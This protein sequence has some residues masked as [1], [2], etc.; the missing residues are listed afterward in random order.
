MKKII[1]F[2]LIVLAIIGYQY[3]KKNK[4]EIKAKTICTD[5]FKTDDKRCLEKYWNYIFYIS[6]DLSD[7]RFEEYKLKVQSVENKIDQLIKENENT[8]INALE[9][10]II[11][12][13]EIRSVIGDEI[14][15]KKV[16][17]TGGN[18]ARFDWPYCRGYFSKYYVCMKQKGYDYDSD[19]E[20]DDKLEVGIINIE[21]FPKV[22][23]I[24]DELRSFNLN[25]YKI[26]VYGEMMQ[27][28]FEPKIDADFI[29][30][31]KVLLDDDTYMDALNS[32]IYDTL[33]DKFTKYYK[34]KFPDEKKVPRHDLTVY[35]KP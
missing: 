28:G 11:P 29:K 21:D 14:V 23:E 30:L 35:N 16:I 10:N 13:H 17:L 15:G 24:I 22:K 3:D 1:F 31:E 25:Y 6:K 9:Y 19:K 4:A 26:T 32:G 27:Q 2:G 33:H 12:F 18:K 20:V 7:E 8:L 5:H 34:E